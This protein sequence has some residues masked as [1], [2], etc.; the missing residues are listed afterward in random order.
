MFEIVIS[1]HVYFLWTLKYYFSAEAR[2]SASGYCVFGDG[3]VD[4][5]QTSLKHHR[6]AKTFR[7]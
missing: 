2:S 7:M 3:V 4:N 5:R 6:S 1:S